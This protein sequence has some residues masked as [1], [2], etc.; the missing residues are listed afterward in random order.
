MRNEAWSQV[1]ETLATATSLMS[2]K[3]GALSIRKSEIRL[4]QIARYSR[5]TGQRA[6]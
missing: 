2:V 5:Y 3:I 6:P 1:L 4:V